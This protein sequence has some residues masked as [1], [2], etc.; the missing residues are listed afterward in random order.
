MALLNGC[1]Q[2]RVTRLFAFRGVQ[3]WRRCSGEDAHL[4]QASLYY[5]RT[6][7]GDTAFYFAVRNGHLEVC[8]L[9][10]HAGIFSQFQ[11]RDYRAALS[12]LERSMVDF[13]EKDRSLLRTIARC[14]LPDRGWI[15]E[16]CLEQISGNKI[17]V[18]ASPEILTLLTRADHNTALLKL[19]DLRAYFDIWTPPQFHALHHA[20]VI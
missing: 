1:A 20:S 5:D 16:N 10:Q 3:E 13:T 9:L 8:R 6:P 17:L 18:H 7:C 2:D 4:H 15:R 14:E 12:A 19:S 11:I